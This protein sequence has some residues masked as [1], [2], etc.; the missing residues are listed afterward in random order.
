MNIAMVGSKYCK[1][2]A[3]RMVFAYGKGTVRPDWKY[4]FLPD[5]RWKRSIQMV[6]ITAPPTF[7]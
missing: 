3:G 1:I 2:V 6:I 5:K 4:E 7:W